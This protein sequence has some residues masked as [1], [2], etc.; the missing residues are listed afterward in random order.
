MVHLKRAFDA[1]LNSREMKQV[2]GEKAY[3]LSRMNE[4][5]LSKLF[6]LLI[7]NTTRRDD[8]IQRLEKVMKEKGLKLWSGF[9]E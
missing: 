5:E 2:I 8:I 9:T 6:W 1:H 3:N 4:R 7:Q